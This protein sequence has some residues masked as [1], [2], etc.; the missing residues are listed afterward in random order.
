MMLTYPPFMQRPSPFAAVGGLPT[1]AQLQSSYPQ[2]AVSGPQFMFTPHVNSFGVQL[3]PKAKCIPSPKEGEKTPEDKSTKN[4]FSIASILGDDKDQKSKKHCA[5]PSS[6]NQNS[7]TTL[8]NGSISYQEQRA[9]SASPVTPLS[10]GPKPNNQFYYLYPPPSH[11]PFA[12]AQSCLENELMHRGA[13]QGRLT[14]PVAVI[15]EIVRNA[16]ETTFL[17]LFIQAQND[18]SSIVC[19][20][21]HYFTH[22]FQILHNII[23]IHVNICTL[24]T[25][26]TYYLYRTL[27]CYRPTFA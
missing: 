5:D 22:C 23:M 16:G 24:V 27:G 26:Y 9:L 11:F 21:N 19:K 1:A 3:S 18:W 20:I 14:A 15:S 6:P 13:L 2:L 17:F 25:N 10:G 8:Y 4:S 12:S 7:M